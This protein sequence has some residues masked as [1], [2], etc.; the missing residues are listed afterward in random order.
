MAGEGSKKL[1]GGR[2][3][4]ETD[5][6]AEAFN[7]SLD[8]D[9]RLWREDLDGS[10]AHARMLARQGILTEEEARAILAGLDRIEKEIE[11]GAFPWRDEY[12]D[13]HMNVE[14]RLTELVGEVGGKLHTAR[15]RNDQV[16]TDLRLWLRRSLA[17]IVEAQQ[18]L[19][20]VL[21]AEAERHL[22]PPVVL[23]GY[24]HL[25]RAQPVLLSH[26]FMA[27]YEMLSRDTTRVLDALFRMD[28]SPLGAAALAGTSFPID[29][30]YTAEQLGFLEPMRNSLDAVASRDFVLE[31]LS[32][33]AIGQL[34]LSRL[35]EELV[36]YSSFEFGFVT[37]PDAFATGSSIMPQKKNPDIP[38]LIRAKA[39]RAIGD[40]VTL[41]TVVKGLPL[42]YNKD[43]QEDKEPVFDAVDTYT[44]SLK[45]MAALL[46]GL[47]WHPEVTKRAAT[48]GFALATD[49]ADYLSRKG[50]PFRRAHAV[51]GRIVRKLQEEGRDLD[52]LDLDELRSFSEL[53]D[54][55]ALALLSVEGSVSS[56]NVYGGTAPEQVRARIA[57][58]KKELEEDGS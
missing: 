33:I 43:L 8:F 5:K 50:L 23:P 1:W 18:E 57:E 30:H 19:A 41:L 6:L 49:L 55:D 15:S 12:E 46:P 10:R 28:E 11:A 13:V 7:N 9:R 34:T 45:L 47:T 21:V 40:L 29:R 44:S 4:G 25:Q 31:A 58:A 35:A 17:G 42:A 26:W 51:V 24:T 20:R 2:F 56:R 53:F 36:L 48:G 52:D 3:A 16:A 37:L 14:A 54:E 27:Y 38:E 39:G 32:A 22:E